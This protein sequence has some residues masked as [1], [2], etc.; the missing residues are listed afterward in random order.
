MKALF[1]G[2]GGIGQRHLRILRDLM[3]KVEISAVRRR[4]RRFE[5]TDQLEADYSVDLIE[6]YQI[7][8]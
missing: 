4:G 7:R 8:E 2:L 3:P 1:V 6:K 5:I